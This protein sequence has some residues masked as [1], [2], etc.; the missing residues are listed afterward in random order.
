MMDHTDRHFRY[1]LRLIT[2]K[3]LLYTE[4]LTTGALIHGER[5]RYLQFHPKEHPLAIQLGG[6]NPQEL[7]IC[8]RIAEDAG[9]DEVNLNIGCP[10]NR[11]QNGRFGACLMTEP[12]LVAECV[13][14]MQAQLSI[15][16]TVK[17]RTG[18]D[19]QDSY[20]LLCRFVECVSKAGCKIFIIHARKAWLSGL[21]PK[22]NREVPPL[23][24]QLVHQL[25]QDFPD[26]IIVINGG[27]T[28]LNQVQDQ[29]FHVDGVMIGRA[30]Y[31]N[32]Y[33]LAETD[34]LI[35]GDQ[36][37]SLTRMEILAHFKSYI[38]KEL[39]KGVYLS[40]MTRHI[41]GLFKG[42]PGARA[43][44]RVISEKAYTPDAG[45]EVIEEALSKIQAT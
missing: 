32:P 33:F 8:A 36:R 3:T 14:N 24:Y 12:D 28:M 16:V 6:S 20:E 37:S 31:Q 11:V 43:Y 10:S 2:R 13:S 45:V 25:K 27:F 35:F 18:I 17:T 19:N 41:L 5:Q 15:P 29:L 30:A 9:F 42:Q 1:F 34:Q 38:Q 21:S 22:E 39:K 4:M 44:R 23:Q 7:Q 40:Q 26:L